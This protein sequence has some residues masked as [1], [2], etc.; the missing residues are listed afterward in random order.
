VGL[1]QL[2]IASWQCSGS[3]IT[4]DPEFPGQIRHSSCSPGSLLSRHGSLW[5]LVVPQIEEATEGFPFWQLRGHHA[6]RGEGAEKPSRRSFP[7][8]LPAVERTLG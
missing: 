1:T 4:P 6:E 3:F 7:E 2:V 5:F 8:M